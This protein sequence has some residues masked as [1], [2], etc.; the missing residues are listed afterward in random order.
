VQGKLQRELVKADLKLSLNGVKGKKKMDDLLKK[1]VEKIVDAEKVDI[2]GKQ[3]ATVATR[4]EIFRSV[5]GADYGIQTEALRVDDPNVARVRAVI[6]DKNGRIVASG[7]AQEDSTHSKINYTSSL[8]V[9]ETSA[10]GRA[11]ACLGLFGSEYA[12][13]DEMIE[14]LAVDNSPVK[15]TIEHRAA[16]ERKTEQKAIPKVSQ[17]EFYQPASSHPDDVAGV[18]AE[19]DKI[20]DIDELTAYRKSLDD[21]FPHMQEEDQKEITATFRSRWKQLKGVK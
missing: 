1:A 14:A 9:A 16:P 2:R 12:S 7:L 10:I 6:V 15:K 4:L 21:I 3:Y 19:V 5:Y 13:A 17:Y 8:E 11:L 20:D 18:Y